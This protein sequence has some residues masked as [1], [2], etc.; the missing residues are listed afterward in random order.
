MS[1]QCAPD[2]YNS[3][4]QKNITHINNLSIF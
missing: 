2:K 3:E 1:E 4:L